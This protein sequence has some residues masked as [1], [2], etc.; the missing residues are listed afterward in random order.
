LKEG[1]GDKSTYLK[2]FQRYPHGA[3]FPQMNTKK[4]FEICL[5]NLRKLIVLPDVGTRL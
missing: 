5:T 3:G 2:G 1:E 4:I